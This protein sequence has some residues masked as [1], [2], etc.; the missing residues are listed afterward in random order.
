M[1]RIEW[2]I[3]EAG[4]LEVDLV[5]HCGGSANGESIH[6]LRGNLELAEAFMHLGRLAYSSS[7]SDSIRLDWVEAELLT[8][9]GDYETTAALGAEMLEALDPEGLNGPLAYMNNAVNW[10]G[11]Q[12][13]SQHR[14]VVP[15]FVSIPLSDEWEQ[16]L[17]Q[18]ANW[19]ERA[20]KLLEVEELRA[21]LQVL[22][23]DDERVT[24]MAR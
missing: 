22:I 23:P 20:G 4:H 10:S 15:Q 17:G 14:A 24:K 11:L 5:H 16:R 13:I 19:Y 1:S 8:A 21:K 6:G 18:L 7:T 2:D 12:H 9:C 3:S